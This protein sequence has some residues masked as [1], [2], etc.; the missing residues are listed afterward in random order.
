MPSEVHDKLDDPITH[1]MRGDVAR[2]RADQTVGQALAEVRKNPPEGRIVYFYVVD[3]DSILQGVVPTRRL[4]LADPATPVRDIMVAEAIS[5]PATATVLDACEFFTLHRLLALPVVDADKKLIGAVDVELYTSELED[6]DRQS[7][8]DDLFQLVGVHLAESQQT[9]PLHAFS[10]RFPWLLA[11]I[12]GGIMAAF[13]S[14]MFAKELEKVVALAMFIPVVLALSESVSIQSV[15]LALQALHGRTPTWS[16]VFARAKREG[17]IGVL[18]GAAC[19]MVV[20]LVALGWLGEWRVAAVIFGGILSGVT[21]AAIM[22]MALP[23]LLRLLQRDPQV[24]AGPVALALTDM[25]TL[26]AY[27]NLARW[28]L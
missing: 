12:A 8:S 24:A 20:G 14:G 7:R 16:A 9:T 19:G 1:H 27:F 23:N 4:I 21:L 11:N 22:G 25:V 6:L 18:L 26:L 28:L 2:L 5:I 10:S 15:S 3:N 13:L 17:A